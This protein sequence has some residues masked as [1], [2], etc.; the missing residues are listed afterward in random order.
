MKTARFVRTCEILALGLFVGGAG[1]DGLADINGIVNCPS[2]ADLQPW[3]ACSGDMECAWDLVSASPNCDGTIITIPTSCVCDQGVWKCPNAY[4]CEP[5][6]APAGDDGS[7]DD[8]S[9]DDGSTDDGST[10]DGDAPTE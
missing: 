3:G 5:P 10:D 6:A 4:A 2:K 9:T 8:G 1:C 7:T